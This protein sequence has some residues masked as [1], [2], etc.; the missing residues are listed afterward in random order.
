MATL[1]TRVLSGTIVGLLLAAAAGYLADPARAAACPHRIRQPMK[2]SSARSTAA[3][4]RSKSACWTMRS[5]TSRKRPTSS[6]VEPAAW[7][8]LALAH[9]RLGEF[10]PAAAAVQRAA[11]LAPA[12][13]E[14]AF[15]QG[16]LET[17]RGRLDQGIAD[18][19]RAIQ[20]D[21]GSLR[22]RYALAQEVERAGGA[23]RRPRR[24][25]VAGRPASAAA[26]QSGRAAG[27]NAPGRQTPRR[28]AAEGV[29]QRAVDVCRRRGPKLP[30][31]S[32]ARSRP[33]PTRA[34]SRT[35]LAPRPSC[36]MCWSAF[37]RFARAWWR[38]N[39]RR[40]SSRS[41]SSGF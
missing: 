17:S 41:R 6:P 20:L 9:L 16:Q 25:A 23:E 14:I 38:S 18:F 11:A 7:A 19:R 8:N 4:R 1:R 12:S 5:G 15:L 26:G 28:S 36:A 39:R 10:D 32:I 35:P 37:R 22:A 3:W 24:A 27:A 29:G 30:W 2:I 21:P 31:N 33:V 40:S 13:G 34:T